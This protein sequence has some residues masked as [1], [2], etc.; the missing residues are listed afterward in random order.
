MIATTYLVDHID[1][2]ATVTLRVAIEAKAV[3]KASLLAV[4]L[5]S[6]RGLVYTLDHRISGG[7]R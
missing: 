7:C 4:N 3:I 1:Y 2:D 5:V 6:A